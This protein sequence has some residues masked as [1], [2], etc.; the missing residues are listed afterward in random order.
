MAIILQ[1]SCHNVHIKNSWREKNQDAAQFPNRTSMCYLDKLFDLLR[2]Q[3]ILFRFEIV[4]CS[5]HKINRC[6]FISG[7]RQE[8]AESKHRV[9]IVDEKLTDSLSKKP[10]GTF[11]AQLQLKDGADSKKELQKTVDKVE[12]KDELLK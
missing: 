12:G 2:S 11:K 4:N 3:I 10:Y 7:D 6:V 8:W 1:Y 9:R 5:I